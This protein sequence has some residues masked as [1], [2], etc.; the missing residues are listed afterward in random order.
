M[1]SD[2]IEADLEV[3]ENNRQRIIEK[4]KNV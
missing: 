3:E 4:V 1:F 2:Y